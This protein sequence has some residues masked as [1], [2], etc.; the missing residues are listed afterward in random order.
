MKFDRVISFE[1]PIRSYN[2]FGE[3]TKTYTH[4][5]LSFAN[6]AYNP[7]R[8]VQMTAAGNEKQQ[9]GIQPVLFTVR[10]KTGLDKTWRIIYEGE[11]YH[12]TAIAEVDRR[13][14]LNIT[15]EQRDNDRSGS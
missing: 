6:V 13:H 2:S 3:E 15:A 14:Y 1:K 10:Y 9:V 4:A 12:I 8:E 7:G 11:V 5:F